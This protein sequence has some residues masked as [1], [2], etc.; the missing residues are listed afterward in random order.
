MY[1]MPSL[2]HLAPSQLITLLQQFNAT[3]NHAIY[4]I[5]LNNE[6][7]NVI[8]L[9]PK[10]IFEIHSQNQLTQ[11]QRQNCSFDDV[12][13]CDTVI[14][15]GADTATDRA[16]KGIDIGELT[17]VLEAYQHQQ[18]SSKQSA[19][20]HTANVGYQDGLMGFISYDLS[21]H[22]LANANY[23][24][25][26][27]HQVESSYLT[28]H[29]PQLFLGHYDIYLTYQYGKWHL[30]TTTEEAMAQAVTIEN[31]LNNLVSDANLPTPKPLSLSPLW[32][33]SAYH[34]AFYKVQDYLTAGDCYQINLTQC[35]QGELSN[36]QL[37]DYLPSLHQSTQ[38][39]FAGYL[40]LGNY[41]LLSCSPEL[42][43]PLP[44]M[45]KAK[46]AL[47]PNPS[48]VHAHVGKI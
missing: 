6:G 45:P 43:L 10:T 48:K 22:H 1:P 4:P 27:A 28:P 39:P 44:T 33:K 14:N 11:K 3:N 8:G 26:S 5:W 20:Q 18:L 32:Q 24:Q 30:H 29:Q 23:V 40:A 13:Y 19:I 37:V 7:Q 9:L 34:Q 2:Q 21:A 46:I 38:A 15:T 12:G 35:W 47:L 16:T 17:A 31:W 42:F 25:A 36:Q 41:E